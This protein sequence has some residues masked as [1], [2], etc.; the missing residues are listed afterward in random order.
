ME[1][2]SCTDRVKGDEVLHTVKKEK[3]ILH[4]IN[5]RKANCISHI[6]RRNCLLKYAVGWRRKDKSDKKKRK[7]T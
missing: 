2:S 1:N 5:T 4:T 6:T 7:K 3:N